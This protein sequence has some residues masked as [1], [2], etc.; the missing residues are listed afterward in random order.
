MKKILKWG[1][2][3]V[4]IEDVT[5][6]KEE[7]VK[8]GNQ[9]IEPGTRLKTIGG[10]KKRSS[11]FAVEGKS[12]EYAGKYEDYLLF[13]PVF[14]IDERTLLDGDFFYAPAYVDASILVMQ[15]SGQ[16]FWSIRY[17]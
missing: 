9:G 12:F 2:T 4:Q 11:L 14:D 16:G 15:S 8:L 1:M 10:G 17:D 5:Q 7:S 3:I 13:K 6:I